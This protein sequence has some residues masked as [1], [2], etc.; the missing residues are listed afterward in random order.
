VGLGRAVGGLSSGGGRLAS[1]RPE[2]AGHGN[3]E[4]IRIDRLDEVVDGAKVVGR[5]GILGIGGDEADLRFGGELFEEGEPRA[6]R[7]IDIEEDDVGNPPLDEGERLLHAP[8]RPEHL[9]LPIRRQEI[10][11]PGARGGF[12]VDEQRRGHR[13]DFRVRN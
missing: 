9:D 12:I 1:K 11:E 7:H 5:D 3:L 8:H 6:S 13:L 4:T 2:D 10:A